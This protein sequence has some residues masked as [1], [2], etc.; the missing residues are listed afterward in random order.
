[1]SKP[2]KTFT[3]SSH[4]G[5]VP[6]K[7]LGQNFLIN[8]GIIWKIVGATHITDRHCIEIWPGLWAITYQILEKQPASLSLIELDSDLIPA[9]VDTFWLQKGVHVLNK[10]ILKVTM[11][12]I[13]WAE[14]PGYTVFWNLPYYITSPILTHLLYA[15]NPRPGECIFM[16]QKEVADKILAHDKKQSV[17]SLMM[18][19]ACTK[20]QKVT[21]VSPGSFRPA[22]KVHS[23][24]L[25]FTLNHNRSNM[26]EKIFMK[27]IKAWFAQKR[28]KLTTNFKNANIQIT[29]STLI[30]LWYAEDVRAEKIQ[31]NDWYKIIDSIT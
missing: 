16:M 3:W 19:H 22:P 5:H 24:V 20:I 9:L 4:E 21:N 10:D 27:I 29:P 7:T 14:K 13:P 25:H 1:M 28:K 23:S 18:H 11:S 2:Q 8:K 6:K 31:L 12:D 17:I 15:S 26:D 30:R